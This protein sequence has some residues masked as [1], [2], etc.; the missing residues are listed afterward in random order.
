[1]NPDHTD[2]A[3]TAVEKKMLAD[4]AS[5]P[6]IHTFLRHYDR[7]RAGD[8][9]RVDE[10]MIVPVRD[11]P[12]PEDIRGHAESGSDALSHSV[13]IKLNGG[14]GTTMGLDQAKS[15]LRV[16]EGLTFLDIIVRQILELR[17]SCTSG[18][19]LM[20][21]NSFSTETDTREKLQN[22]RELS[23]GQEGLPL[24]F[25]QN[26]VPRIRCDTLYPVEWPSAPE[27]EWCPPGHG[28]LYIALATTGLLDQ[29]IDRGIRFAFVSNA[30]NLG[31]SM[32]LDILGYFANSPGSFMMEV[33]TRT[34]ADRKGGHLAQLRDGRLTLRESAQCPENE[35]DAFQDITKY[36][37]FNTNNLWIK[38]D[39]LKAK[40][41][42]EHGTLPL[43]T[44]VN[45]KKAD[46]HEPDA[47][48]VYQLESAMGAAISVFEESMALDIPRT[49]FTPVKTTDD[50]LAI[51]SDAYV[52]SRD[53]RVQPNPARR[54]NDLVIH[55]DP[56]YYGRIQ[57]FEDRFAE[58]PPS[59][60][61]CDRLKIEGDITFGRRIR[62]IGDAHLRNAS[63]GPVRLPDGTTLTGRASPINV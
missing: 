13:V 10:S 61:E 14:L 25:L 49:R 37:Y 35:Q 6:L 46:P 59:L 27:R 38:L 1:M 22:Y 54:R 42:S 53:Y 18:L 16:K 47:P 29:L 12:G 55:L 24:T 52:L 43:P 41:M 36:R 4:G 2:R 63:S 62:I 30:D 8:R 26:R 48:Y 34:E 15:L 3:R 51:R 58:D 20:F 32:D 60:L 28:D 5:R 31:A 17:R 33:T 21:M 44:I 45:R 39:A 50:L 7:L 11:L 19:P 23:R 56:R 40:L 57:D 9:G